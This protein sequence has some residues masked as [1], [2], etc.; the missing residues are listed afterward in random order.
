MRKKKSGTKNNKTT[1]KKE[2]GE[3]CSVMQHN[4][5]KIKIKERQREHRGKTRHKQTNK[6]TNRCT[7]GMALLLLLVVE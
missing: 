3:V 6:Q 7:N 5:D 1:E 4:L 2:D